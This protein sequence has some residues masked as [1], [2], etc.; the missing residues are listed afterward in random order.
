M[1]KSIPQCIKCNSPVTDSVEVQIEQHEKIKLG[2][3]IDNVW[4]C[5]DCIDNHK[6]QQDYIL[7][8]KEKTTNDEH[9]DIIGVANPSNV[10]PNT[11]KADEAD[12]L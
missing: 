12:I 9:H 3:Y 2:H 8:T 5:D 1:S 4:I 11:S 7:S 10:S 6:K